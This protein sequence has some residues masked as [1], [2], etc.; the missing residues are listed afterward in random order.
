MIWLLLEC[1]CQR[2][3]PDQGPLLPVVHQ[4]RQKPQRIKPQRINPQMASPATS[5]FTFK[6][7][8]SF[9]NPRRRVHQSIMLIFKRDELGRKAKPI[10][11]DLQSCN[12]LNNWT[13]TSGTAVCKTDTKGWRI[14]TKSFQ[15][16][17]VSL[18]SFYYT[19]KLGLFTVIILPILGIACRNCKKKIKAKINGMIKHFIQPMGQTRKI[20]LHWQIFCFLR[21][22]SY[23]ERIISK[24]PV[25]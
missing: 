5:I 8:G 25:F 15:A 24:N 7:R 3:C 20:L 21:V 16:S 18:S 12:D 22:S 9:S 14:P 17:L 19:Q 23:F 2:T 10:V 11:R 13:Q 4:P 6:Q 1:L